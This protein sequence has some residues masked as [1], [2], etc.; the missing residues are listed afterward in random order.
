MNDIETMPRIDISPAQWAI[1][2]DILQ[3]YVPQFAVWAFG[4]R[5]TG[6]AKKYSDLDLAVITDKPLSLSVSADLA[7]AF[8][9]SDLPWKVDV[10]DWAATSDA[11]RRIIERDKIVVKAV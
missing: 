5:A 1:I 8:S 10:V 11:F 6:N 9:D 3:K 4:S 2:R 7:E